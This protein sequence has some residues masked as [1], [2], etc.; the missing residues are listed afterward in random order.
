[1]KSQLICS[2]ILSLLAFG[3]SATPN[4]AE[5]KAAACAACH[6]ETGVSAV[7]MYPN[8]A[9]QKAAYLEKQLKAFKSGSRTDPTMN[10][11]AKSLS[12]EDI[13]LLAEYFSTM[14]R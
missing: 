3:A 13:K 6:G 11:M 14:K 12:G 2:L 5:Q 7:P 8:L 1:M 10:A 4:V 9:G